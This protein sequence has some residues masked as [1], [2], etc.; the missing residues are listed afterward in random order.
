MKTLKA[1]GLLTVILVFVAMNGCTGKDKSKETRTVME[2]NLKIM[3]NFIKSV[4]ETEDPQV[5]LSALQKMKSEMQKL[6]PEMNE[7]NKKYPELF[8]L[9]DKKK[10]TPE[11]KNILKELA[12]REA[13]VRP[14]FVAALQKVM[15]N[16]KD[17]EIMKELQEIYE[18]Q[19]EMTN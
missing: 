16:A 8:K 5:Y 15:K 14:K 6:I 7:L 12:V 13:E 9:D 18:L 2:K 19:K 17:P 10:P 11:L 1:L 4:E 3:E